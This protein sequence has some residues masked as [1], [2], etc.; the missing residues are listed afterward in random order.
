MGIFDRCF[1][2]SNYDKY[3]DSHIFIV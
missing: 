1:C 3:I 2:M